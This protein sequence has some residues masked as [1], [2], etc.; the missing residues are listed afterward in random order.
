MEH[1][2]DFCT[3]CR[4]CEQL[5]PTHS[6]N[7]ISDSEGFLT[8]QIEQSTCIDCGLCEKRCPQNHTTDLLSDVKKTYAAT[9]KDRELLYRSASG[10]AF[11]GIANWAIENGWIVFG[12][13]YDGNLVAHHA[14][15]ETKEELYDL[16]SSKYVQSDT[17]HTFCEVKN[18]LKEG[19]K[20]L[21]SGTGCQIG[22]LKSFLK[23]NY[24][25]LVT[26][27]LICH[28]VPSPL[29]FA[30]YIET[31]KEKHGVTKIEE[32]DFRDKSGGW[33]L[34]YRYR[35]RYRYRYGSSTIDPY[36]SYFLKGYT[37]RECCYKC[38]YACTKR[39]GDIT[40]ADYWGIEK[41]HP[42]FYNV[43]GVSLILI[44]TERG[45]QTWNQVSSRFYSIES[46]V[47]DAA[48]YNG[49]L[50]HSTKREDAIRDYIY[51]GIKE[52]TATD[53]IHQRLPYKIPIKARV[54]EL[55]PKKIIIWI[56]KIK[57]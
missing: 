27:D 34:G 25:N 50:R 9:L 57:K 2:T 11:A 38:H 3:G 10:G 35:Y 39:T 52:M 24:D 31:L 19:R 37:Y 29:L 41:I 49:N 43:K 30:K 18:L 55:I 51:K 8:A 17:L 5:C 15:A 1:I 33:G 26:I 20:V 7:M 12:V 56:K 16:L 4:T 40:I 44:S 13:R 32:Y 36:F 47:E 46:N 28:G 45:I 6:I 23:K 21:Y 14:K 48:K 53:Y 22:G 42:S 54:K